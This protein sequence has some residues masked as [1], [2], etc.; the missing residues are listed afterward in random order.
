M[1]LVLVISVVGAVAVP[2]RI[3]QARR[4]AH[5]RH[6]VSMSVIAETA[7]TRAGSDGRP[8]V[9]RSSAAFTGSGETIVVAFAPK[10]ASRGRFTGNT[11]R[12][13]AASDA[14]L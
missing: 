10:P 3:G 1:A 7:A 11:H 2:L 4:R 8:G 9:V 5:S 12:P 6:A 13:R 14:P